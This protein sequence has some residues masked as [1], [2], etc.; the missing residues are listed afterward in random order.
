MAVGFDAVTF[1]SLLELCGSRLSVV[2]GDDYRANHEPAVLEFAS[3]SEYVLV[4]GDAK[5]GTF[6]VLLNVGGTDNN[7]YFN[8]VAD[9]LKHAQFAVGHKSWQYA[10]GVMVVKQFAAKFQIELAVKLRNTFFDVFRLN[11]LIL[12]VVKSYSHF[13]YFEFGAKLRKTL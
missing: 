13:V 6:L 7:N 4:V 3:E 9:F 5:V 10:A 11:A 12:F 8:A 2:V 1:K